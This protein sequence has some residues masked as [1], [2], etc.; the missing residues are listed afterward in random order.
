MKKIKTVFCSAV[1]CLLVSVSFVG[2][3]ET[4]YG[5][6]SYDDGIAADGE[7]YNTKEFYRNELEVDFYADPGAIYVTEGEDKGW[8][9]TYGT[10]GNGGGFAIYRSKDFSS[11]E[12]VGFADVKPEGTWVSY[13]AWAPEVIYMNGKYYMYFSASAKNNSKYAGHYLGLA[14][15]D[16][17]RGPFELYESE[18]KNAYGETITKSAPPIVFQDH[19]EEMR[20][21]GWEIPKSATNFG[22]IDA[23]PFLDAN[24]DL[25]LYFVPENGNNPLTGKNMICGMKMLDPATPDYSTVTPLVASK[26]ETIEKKEGQWKGVGETGID[27]IN[28]GPFMT[29][30]VS[31]RPDGTTATKYY[32]TYSDGESG[33]KNPFYRVFTAIS[34]TPLGVFEKDSATPTHGIAS[35]FNHMSGTAHHSIVEAGG[36]TFIFYHAHVKRNLG[37]TNPRALAVDRMAWK[38]DET[39]GYDRLYSNG[40]T[41]SLAPLP[42]VTSGKSNLA[43][44]AAFYA[45]NAESGK[46]TNLLRDGVIPIH[47]H[48][49]ALEFRFDGSA[50]IEITL[51]KPSEVSSLL[52]YNSYLFE[53]AFSKIDKITLTGDGKT[54]VIN[55]LAFNPA[56]YDAETKYIR[57]GA[58][59]VAAFEE[60]LKV[61]KITV[62]IW[63]KI[64]GTGVIGVGDIAIMGV[65]K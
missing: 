27:V 60:P 51:K 2:C 37:D 6:F 11:W 26:Y 4:T 32:L 35:G 19:F 53:N 44:T 7:N 34:D 57:P 23:S 42:S 43:A 38:Y 12:S 31:Q 29:R 24:G 63:T 33:Y 49:D 36:E 56:Y 13:D 21:S 16:S 50:K 5:E 59:A 20:A 40:P 8:F 17:P 30:H 58:A 28:E 61:T 22:S 25:Y 52:V 9:F 18:T 48:S 14:V 55:D 1:A 64:A 41:Y 62:E 39:L 15:S 3:G 65:Q 46:S 47:D 45:S 10:T 54:Y